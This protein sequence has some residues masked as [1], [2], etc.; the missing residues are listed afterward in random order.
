VGY[1]RQLH[2]TIVPQQEA[3]GHMHH[4]LMFEQYLALGETTHGSALAPGQP[5]SID[6][7]RR[8]ITELAGMFPGSFL[9]VGADEVN[10]LGPGKAAPPWRRAEPPSSTSTF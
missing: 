5:G 4:T 9:R 7:V 3:F 8:W 2:V 10:E 6:L 1:A